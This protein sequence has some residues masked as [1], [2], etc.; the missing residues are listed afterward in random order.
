MEK[1][2]TGGACST[3]WGRGEA[4]TGYWWGNLR[5]RDHLGDPGVDEKII[6]RWVFRK[7]DVGLRTGS[8]W[9]R[10]GTGGTCEC[11]SIK[12]GEFLD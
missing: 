5:E 7:W 8:S 12:F 3:Y 9:L 2:E 1:N 10:I 11:G 6:S 4:C